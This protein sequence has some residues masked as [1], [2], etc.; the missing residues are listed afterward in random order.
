M[1]S[2]LKIAYIEELRCPFSDCYQA[3]IQTFKNLTCNLLGKS[4]LHFFDLG[5]IKVKKQGYT[6]FS[7]LTF[8]GWDVV[9]SFEKRI[10]FIFM[11]KLPS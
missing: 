6:V 2:I 7:R 4:S 8:P 10:V 3:L 9:K 5:K 1:L 11:N